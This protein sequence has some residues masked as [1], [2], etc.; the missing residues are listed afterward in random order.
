MN[1]R[2]AY[3]AAEQARTETAKVQARELG[4]EVLTPLAACRLFGKSPEA[5]RKAVRN[6]HVVVACDLRVTDKTVGLIRLDS[7]ISYWGT[8]GS[9][10]FDERLNEMRDNG[11]MMGI[12]GVGYNILH[13]TPLQTLRDGD[14]LE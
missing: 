6:G 2:D 10:D 7:A 12:W 1:S 13:P 9:N 3:I 4:F 14:E 8:Q 5:V 11:Q